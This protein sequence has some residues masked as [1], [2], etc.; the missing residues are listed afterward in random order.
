MNPW[1][2][3]PAVGRPSDPSAPRA[4]TADPLGAG[5]KRD[6]SWCEVPAASGAGAADP[7]AGYL[8]KKGS[9]VLGWGSA[10]RR[11]YF[12]LT[13]P[14]ATYF[15]DKNGPLKGCID[16]AGTTVA[17]GANGRA[18]TPTPC[19]TPRPVPSPAHAPTAANRPYP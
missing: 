4:P 5:F 14:N 18:P 3:R 15:V 1:A 13:G 9:G 17:G 12:V 8:Q 6:E 16:L 2:P 19:A 10:W 11:R 7:L